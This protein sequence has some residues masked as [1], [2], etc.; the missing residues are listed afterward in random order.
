M[1]YDKEWKVIEEDHDK[2]NPMLPNE[3]ISPSKSGLNLND[4]LIMQKWIDY[5]KG[6][7]DQQVDLLK[8]NTICYQDVYGLAKTRLNQFNFNH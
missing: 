5:A 3:N 8:Q 6:V 4:V 1:N 2:E 7:G